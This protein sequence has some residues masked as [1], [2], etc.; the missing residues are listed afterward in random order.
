MNKSFFHLIISSLSTLTFLE[1]QESQFIITS[2]SPIK[3]PEKTRTTYYGDYEDSEDRVAKTYSDSDSPD[4]GN[5]LHSVDTD[6]II[7]FSFIINQFTTPEMNTNPS[8]NSIPTFKEVADY[9][10]SNFID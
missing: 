10:N 9:H 4:I 6:F 2:S 5:K 1:A 3:I 8:E 7:P